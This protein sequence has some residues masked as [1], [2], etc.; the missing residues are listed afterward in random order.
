MDRGTAATTTCNWCTRWTDV[1]VDLCAF[2]VYN[3]A[4]SLYSPGIS[5]AK[6]QN[7]RLT[8]DSNFGEAKTEDFNVGV[9][10][11]CARRRCVCSQKRD[12]PMI[13]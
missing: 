8:L 11:S 5:M 4:S 2:S 6:L 3:D 10:P 12:V 9:L 1:L 13:L 7:G